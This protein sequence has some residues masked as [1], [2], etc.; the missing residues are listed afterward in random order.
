MPGSPSFAVGSAGP[1]TFH[2]DTLVLRAGS[3]CVTVTPTPQTTGTPSPT[4]T[5]TPR[6]PSP[7]A[8]PPGGSQVFTGTISL[9][10]AEQIGRNWLDDPA[11]SCAEPQTCTRWDNVPRR[12][13]IY[14]LSNPSGSASCVTVE[15]N[16]GECVDG[17]AI[18]SAAYLNYFDPNS[19]CSYF[20]GDTGRWPD[21]VKSYSFVV[22]ANTTLYV[23]VNEVNPG[24]GCGGYTLTVTGLPS[25]SCTGA[26]ATPGVPTRT[27]TATAA[28]TGTVVTTA[29]VPPSATSVTP[30]TA[31]LTPAVTGTVVGGCA[32]QFSDV[33]AGSTFYPYVRCLACSGMLIGYADGTFRPGASLTRGQ[34]AKLVSNAAGYSEPPAGQMFE[35]VPPGST[36]Y[37]YVG[38]M[39]SR[40]ILAGYEC[41]GASEPCGVYG[42]PFFRPGA[43]ATRGQISKI[44]ANALGVVRPADGQMFEDVPEGTAF[45]PHIQA[46]G[47][48][49]VMNGYPCGGAGEPCGPTNMAYFRPANGVTRG[50]ASK[51]VA[52]AFFPGCSA[53][54]P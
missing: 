27:P 34:L 7:T 36:F 13:D 41:G 16:A 5:R 25:G 26:T 45:Y 14:T 6:P 40:A 28:I 12:Y 44:V 18:Q 3:P 11:S 23:V 24:A 38:R 2:A 39:A 54:S 42:M 33:E 52:N 19:I 20:A 1:D 35:D 47:Q 15:V 48:Q 4:A 43:A 49:G 50:Q 8:C 51:I 37:E 31:S 29:T 21:P 53:Q 32:I 10:D 17:Q 9:S 46:L 22:P 30:A